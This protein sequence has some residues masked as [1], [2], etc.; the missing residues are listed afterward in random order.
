MQTF[1]ALDAD[2]NRYLTL[3]ELRTTAEF[4]HL[5]VPELVEIVKEY[6]QNFD[7]KISQEE[8]VHLMLS[9]QSEEQSSYTLTRMGV[10][11]PDQMHKKIACI[12]FNAAWC[13][14]QIEWAKEI[15][16]H[17]YFDPIVVALILGPHTP[18]EGIQ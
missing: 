17:P 11:D 1:K 7:G 3:P 5:T 12:D 6:D 8:F 15:V 13:F 9:I 4:S 16:E 10:A 2:G 18:G 14:Q